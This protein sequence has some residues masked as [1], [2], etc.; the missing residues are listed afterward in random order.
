MVPIMHLGHS[1]GLT[2][3]ATTLLAAA[4]AVGLA[5]GCT[6]RSSETPQ[7]SR[8]V[9]TPV[10]P[11][12]DTAQLSGSLEVSVSYRERM[13]LPDGSSLRVT[14]ADVSRADAPGEVIAEQTITAQ[15]GPPYVVTLTYDP[16]TI[17]NRSRYAVS[18]RIE[19]EGKLLFITDTN[20]PALTG[21]AP[22]GRVEVVTR[23]AAEEAGSGG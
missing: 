10:R 6:E 20:N 11:A 12:E 22:K 1:I 4:L 9:V 21:G 3:L 13:M 19:H 17:Q 16:T 7:S 18:A 5:S 2:P 14:L 15:G 8:D 23:R